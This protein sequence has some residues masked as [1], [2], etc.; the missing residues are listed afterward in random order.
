MSETEHHPILGG[1]PSGRTYAVDVVL[2]DGNP[3]TVAE[4]GDLGKA[5]ERAEQERVLL[6]KQ[7]YT[8]FFVGVRDADDGERGWL[9]EDDEP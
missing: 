9:S 8:R 5:H 3:E 6:R 2:A 7:N 4:Y 1:W